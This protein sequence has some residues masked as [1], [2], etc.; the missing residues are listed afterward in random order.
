MMLPMS[1]AIPKLPLASA[2]PKLLVINDIQRT[3][4]AP[5][6]IDTTPPTKT[7]QTAEKNQANDLPD[8]AVVLTPTNAICRRQQELLDMIESARQVARAVQAADNIRRG[9]YSKM[10]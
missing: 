2:D 6:A 10:Y 9:I 1:N 7:H 5:P 3:R 8:S 4:S